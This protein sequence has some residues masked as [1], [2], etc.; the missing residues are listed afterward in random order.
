MAAI[1]Q[2]NLDSFF[3]GQE[4][5]EI[6]DLMEKESPGIFLSFARTSPTVKNSLTVESDATKTYRHRQDARLI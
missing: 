4:L 6:A 5:I 1:L 3:D 2:I